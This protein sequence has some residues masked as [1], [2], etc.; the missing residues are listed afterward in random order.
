MVP[1]CCLRTGPRVAAEET[2][3]P[4]DNLSSSL[5]RSLRFFATS[6]SS[7]QRNEEVRGKRRR[8]ATGGPEAKARGAP[9]DSSLVSE[10]YPHPPPCCSHR[11]LVGVEGSLKPRSGLTFCSLVG[12]SWSIDASIT[13][14][15]P[16]ENSLVLETPVFRL[17][18]PDRGRTRMQM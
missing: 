13:L 4:L 14:P 12:D 1:C 5:P 16:S 18:R 17:V 8:P 9:S 3:P 2:P 6:T 15:R 7:P 11:I 10:Q